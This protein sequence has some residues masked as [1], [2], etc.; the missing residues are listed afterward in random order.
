[1]KT[2]QI[3][4]LR[5]CRLPSVNGV[6]GLV[7]LSVTGTNENGSGR[8]IGDLTDVALRG[9]LAHYDLH[10]ANE[11]A[12]I[13]RALQTDHGEITVHEG[14]PGIES[15]LKFWSGFVGSRIRPVEWTCEN[16]AAVHR[17]NVGATVGETYA[18][19][20]RCGRIQRITTASEIPARPSP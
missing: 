18:R 16:C 8:K 6:P 5:L 10:P 4:A 1:M 12:V 13:R 7:A 2:Q 17:D 9:R 15:C 11:V 19:A 3:I 14:W 20:C